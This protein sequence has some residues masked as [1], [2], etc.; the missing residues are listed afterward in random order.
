[1]LTTQY[2]DEADHLADRIVIIDHG[3]TIAEG[4]PA[5]LKAR[6]G[7][8]VVEAT[9]H[10]RALAPA[11]AD[12]L[13]SVTGSVAQID[14]DTGRVSVPVG[15]GTAGLA[16]ALRGLDARHLVR[17]RPGLAPPD[18]RRDLPRP[19]RPHH[20]PPRPRKDR[21]MTTVT[22][23]LDDFHKQPHP[24]LNASAWGNADLAR[25][26]NGAGFVTSSLAVAR[27]TLI[28]FIRTPQLLVVGTIQG[29]MF[30]LIFRY[31]FGGAI[32]GHNGVSYVNFLVPGFLVAGVLFSG[33]AAAAGVAED[34]Q[35]GVVDRLRSLPIPRAA[36][37]H[38]SGARRD[39]ARVWGILVTAG[40]GFLVGFRPDASVGDLLVALG[41]S[42]SSGSR[43]RGSSSRSASCPAQPKPP[44]A[45]R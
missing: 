10:E 13:T 42:T 15:N 18:A 39:A 43:S 14:A 44:R 19:H 17:R 11:V 31:V 38:R 3:R 2:L 24:D 22:T 29:A 21:L 25:R 32:G 45:C 28:A 40:V 33:M 30:L 27:R 12:V 36:L 37:G 41:L 8:D 4:T 1:M 5:E 23:P 35:R 16:A 6:A 20:R 9:A 7:Q 34:V 26:A